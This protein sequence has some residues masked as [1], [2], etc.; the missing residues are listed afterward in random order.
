MIELV[1]TAVG[2]DRP[3]L[4]EQLT[5]AVFDAGGNVADSRM[6]NLRGQFALLL[7]AEAPD[8]PAADRIEKQAAEAARAANLHLTVVRQ[9]HRDAP[10]AEGLPLRLRASAV[11]KPGIVHQL[12]KALHEMGV[13]IEQLT[14]TLEPASYAAPPVFNVDMTVTVPR[15]IPVRKLRE[16]LTRLGDDLNCDIVIEP[17]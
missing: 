2:P 17:T 15:D 11:D 8:P 12:S 6:V 1:I 10:A 4:V 13:N 7:L 16:H 14:T 9:P 5:G 3:G